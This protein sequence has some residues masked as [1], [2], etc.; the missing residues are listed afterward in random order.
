MSSF[1]RVTV[2]DAPAFGG[3]RRELVL[4]MSPSWKCPVCSAKLWLRLK[5]ETDDLF[6]ERCA[7]HANSPSCPAAALT[8]KLQAR[9]LL[10][11]VSGSEYVGGYSL[12]NE[13]GL[14]ERHRSGIGE[15]GEAIW[16]A[17]GPTW[18]VEYEE[19]LRVRET[20]TYADRLAKLRDA[21]ADPERARAFMSLLATSVAEPVPGGRRRRWR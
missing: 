8:A 19:F 18:A 4:P 14:V 13:A 7:D 6:R 17:W 15:H 21:S 10:N 2:Q 11:L 20:A 5:N 12:L 16:E 1:V 9:S 3:E